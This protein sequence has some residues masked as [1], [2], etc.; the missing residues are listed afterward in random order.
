MENSNQISMGRVFHIFLT[1]CAPGKEAEFNKWYEE[2]HIALIRR[3]NPYLKAV[4]RFSTES[5]P[6]FMAIYEYDSLEDL[7]KWRA[8]PGA[9]EA[10]ADYE[11]QIGVLAKGPAASKVYTQTF[12]K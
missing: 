10:K 7:Q 3:K 12:P 6:R 9:L 11:K 5:E 8:S 2:Q 1:E 4:R